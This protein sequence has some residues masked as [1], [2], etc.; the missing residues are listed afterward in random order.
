LKAPVFACL[1]LLFGLAS[2]SSARAAPVG[3]GVEAAAVLAIEADTGNDVIAKTITN[4]MR[5]RVLESKEFTLNGESPSLIATAYGAKCSLKGLKPSVTVANERV[6]DAGC[7]RRIGARFRA[8]QFFWGL[9]YNEGTTT[10]VRLHFWQ[11]GRD[12]ATTLAYDPAARERLADRFYRKLVT[13]WAVGDLSLSGASAGEL[14]IDGKPAGP[15]TDGVELT[16]DTGLHEIEVRNGTR[17]LASA[18]ARVESAGRS[19]VRLTPLVDTVPAPAPAVAYRPPPV[20]V[21]PPSSAWPWVFGGVSAA[22]VVGAGVFWTIRSSAKRDAEIS[23]AGNVCPERE[24]DAVDR[25]NLY[26]TISAISLGVG[27]AA[28]AGL[29]TYTIMTKR[30]PKVVGAVAPVAGGVALGVGGRF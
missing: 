20:V 27:V 5:Q 9:V 12:R 24:R 29:V 18:R 10:L 25:A 21:P 13:P 28:G 2:A 3:A 6:F 19:D 14:F 26:G 22:G 1:A 17:V 16:V 30:E 23:C 11:N 15:Y 4:N 8:R 7:L